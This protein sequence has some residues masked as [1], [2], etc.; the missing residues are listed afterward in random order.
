[1]AEELLAVPGSPGRDVS[2]RESTLPV[3]AVDSVAAVEPGVEPAGE[4]PPA[5]AMEQ[6]AAAGPAGV[7]LSVSAAESATVAPAAEPVAAVGLVNETL[8]VLALEPAAVEES[9]AGVLVM[10]PAF[11]SIQAGEPL[12]GLGS[13]PAAGRAAADFAHCGDA[14]AGGASGGGARKRKAS[15]GVAEGSRKRKK[16]SPVKIKDL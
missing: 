2:A 12:P 11:Y 10:E 1:M 15:A 5:P 8:S 4:R 14:K 6:A 16:S 3:P 13:I 9:T 7:E